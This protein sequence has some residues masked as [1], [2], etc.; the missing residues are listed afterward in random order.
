[1]TL[2][3]LFKEPIVSF[4]IVAL[5]ISGMRFSYEYEIVMNDGR[6]QVSRYEIRFKKGE[7]ERVPEARAACPEETV[8]ELLN[9]CKFL[10]WDGFHGSHPNGVKDG[11]M[12][13]LQAT[14]NGDRKI[15]AAGSENF[16]RHYREFIDGLRGILENGKGDV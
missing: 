11:T 10:A 16:P 9:E 4:E 7:D 1:M 3:K 8:L 6:A 15:Y 14:V 13:T 12:F 2:Q 5:R